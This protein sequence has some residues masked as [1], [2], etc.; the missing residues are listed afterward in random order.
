MLGLGLLGVTRPSLWAD[1][2][3]TWGMATTPWPEM[4]AVLRWVDAIIG[5]YYAVEH[6]WVG[7]VGVSDLTLRLPSV[8]AMAAAAGLVGALGARLATHRVGLMAGLVFAVLPGTSRYA[9]EAR[10]YAFTTFFAVLATYLLF[11]SLR[12]PNFPRYLLYTIAV[13][14]MGVLH[15]IALLLLV[16]HGWVVFAQY[17]RQTLPWL[18]T[19][20]FAAAP[21]LPLLRLAGKQKSQVAWIPHPTRHSLMVFPQDLVGVFAIGILLIV[22]AMFSLPLRR[23]TAMYTAWAVLPLLG[24]FA[25]GQV[26][27]LFL[28]R[29]LMFTLPAWALLAGVALGRA[30]LAVA[31]AGVLAIA[32]LAV[33]A[34]IAVRAPDGHG[35]ATR[36]MALTIAGQSQPGDAVVY[37]MTDD[38]GSW[39]GRDSVN[40]YISADRRPRDVLMTVPSRTS[41]NLAAQE[42]AE[43]A[44]CLGDTPRIWVV[45]LGYRADPLRGLDG[46]KEPALRDG[47]ELAQTWHFTGLTLALVTRR[48]AG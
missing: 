43:V 20:F 25:A 35:E 15:P 41:G 22:L 46:Q 36:Q 39:V 23:P 18:V 44:R 27:P 42:C 21:A 47:Y 4:L 17:R 38:G 9:Q 28:P 5:P 29:Y 34:Q 30:H 13:L 32:A 45:R 33:P 37:G 26:T 6:A 24:L 10:T 8:I 16:A 1:E 2:L 40:H 3:Q 12:R 19:A 11:A 48:T 31:I 14:L 7:L